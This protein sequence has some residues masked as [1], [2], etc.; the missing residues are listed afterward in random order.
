MNAERQFTSMLQKFENRPSFITEMLL[1]KINDQ[2]ASLMEEQNLT[3]KELARRLDVKP[4]FITKILNG[5]PNV[6]LL[7]LVRIAVALDAELGV[8]IKHKEVSS[9]QFTQKRM[10]SVV[11]GAAAPALSSDD[12]MT[13]RDYI[14]AGGSP[15]GQDSG[16][17]DDRQLAA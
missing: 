10:S 15:S 14:N 3:K 17:I 6:T 8:E 13:L 12:G 7:T 16:G 5:M 11:Q 9:I 2:I 4:P 1:L